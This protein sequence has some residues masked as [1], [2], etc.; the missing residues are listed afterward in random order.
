MQ[1]HG[2]TLWVVRSRSFSQVHRGA[3]NQCNRPAL[4]TTVFHSL[5]GS[6]LRC[7]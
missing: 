3:Q 5:T 4:L 1:S 7:R 2:S 6:E